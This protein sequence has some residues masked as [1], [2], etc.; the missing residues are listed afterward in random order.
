MEGVMLTFLLPLGLLAWTIHLMNPASM[1]M[2]T[3]VTFMEFLV[4]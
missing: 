3:R 4:E 1:D 2:I